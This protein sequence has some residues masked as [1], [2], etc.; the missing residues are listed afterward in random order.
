MKQKLLL[1]HGALGS[2]SQLEPIKSLLESKYEVH[3]INFS[4]HGG[5][6]IDS[7]YSITQFTHDVI[8]YLDTEA[9][10]TISIFGYSMGGYVAL[11]IAIKY[12]TRI[13]KIITFGTKFDWST[14]S[15][16]KEVL[17]LDPK[18]IESKVPKYTEHLRAL[19]HPTD[20]EEVLG[21][22]VEL[23]LNLSKKEY[24]KESDLSKI[25]IPVTIGLGTAD[26][27]VGEN[28]SRRIVN[29]LPDSKFSLLENIP[30]PIDRIDP[31]IIAT[32]ILE[33]MI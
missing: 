10:E 1:L 26:K 23:M 11:D 33:E 29:L 3:S 27:M 9:I 18:K 32:Y 15:A 4:G 21:N 5:L 28:E 22:T 31:S 8:T 19:H 14:E 24:L 30:H 7:Y 25:N 20:W 6:P 12:P 17:L 16:Q 13:N 2:K